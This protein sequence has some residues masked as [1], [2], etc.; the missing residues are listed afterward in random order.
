MYTRISLLLSVLILGSCQHKPAD[1]KPEAKKEE[2]RYF[3][4]REFA[5]DQFDVYWGQPL[6]AEKKET[7]DGKTDTSLLSCL[8]IDWAPI[9]ETFFET[10]ISAP[11]FLGKYNF[12]IIDDSLTV[13]RTYYYEAKDKELFTRTLQIATD[14][15]TDKVKSIYVETE[16]NGKTQKLYYA[17][18]RILQIQ[19]FESTASGKSKNL[20][21]E[22]RFLQE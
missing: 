1:K 21:T 16:R 20:R 7:F 6:M 4:V 18:V 8:N 9:L 22:Y 10:D 12:S 11:K 13:S 2:G 19:Q 15:F 5:K 3:S 17:P 14:P